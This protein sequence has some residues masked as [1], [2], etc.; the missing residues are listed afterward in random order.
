MPKT[1]YLNSTEYHMDDTRE[2]YIKLEHMKIHKH[3]FLFL[4]MIFS[5]FFQDKMLSA[6]ANAHRQIMERFRFLQTQT[7]VRMT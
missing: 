3:I 5:F 7:Q 6:Q 2:F 4:C 1:E